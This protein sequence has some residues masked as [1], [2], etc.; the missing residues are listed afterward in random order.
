MAEDTIDIHVLL[1]SERYGNGRVVTI[2]R[3]YA[4]LRPNYP[5]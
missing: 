4:G 5:K 3:V 2:G 1:F